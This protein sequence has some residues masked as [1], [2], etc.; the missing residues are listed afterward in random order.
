MV[1]TLLEGR[2]K[3][4]HVCFMQVYL[5][6]GSI[7]LKASR[8]IHFD[9][10]GRNP[11]AIRG[12]FVWPGTA[13]IILIIIRDHAAALTWPLTTPKPRSLW[14][15]NGLPVFSQSLGVMTMNSNPVNNIFSRFITLPTW[16]AG[17]NRAA[18]FN[19]TTNR[20]SDVVIEGLVSFFSLSFAGVYGFNS[21][22][23]HFLSVQVLACSY[24]HND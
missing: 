23:Q 8:Q 14:W 3:I 18:T 7:C 22:N 17:G 13:T 11:F 10:K 12:V 9:I 15:L 16:I 6:S 20:T 2:N 1:L 4:F 21:S 5:R 24:E 19:V